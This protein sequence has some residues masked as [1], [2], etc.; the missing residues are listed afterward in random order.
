MSSAPAVLLGSQEPTLKVLPPMDLGVG[1]RGDDAV[2]LAA[3]AGLHLDPW[4]QE[5]LRASLAEGTDGRWASMI[6]GVIVARQNGKGSIL[7]A[8]ELA[9]LALIEESLILHSA[10]EFKTAI[11]AFNRILYLIENTP[12]LDKEC[13]RVIR[14]HGDEGVEFRNGSRLKFVARGSG[15]GR[16][17]SAPL[18]ILDEA[19]RISPQMIAAMMPLLSA[20]DNPQVWYTTSVPLFIDEYSEQVRRLA[21]QARDGGTGRMAWFEWSN[22]ADVDAYDEDAMARVNPAWGHRVNVDWVNEVE[23]PTMGPTEFLVERLSVWPSEMQAQW[24]IPADA[25]H[26]QADPKAERVE[27]V[28]FALDVDPDR[29]RATVG[30][31]W[32]RPDGSHHVAVVDNRRGV[33]WVVDLCDRWGAGLHV[34]P[35]SPAGSLIPDLEAAG[36]DV[37]RVA[38]AEYAAACGMFFDGIVEGSVHHDGDEVLTEAVSGAARRNLSEAWAWD[39]RNVAVDITPLVAVTLALWGSRQAADSPKPIFVH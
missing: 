10:H 12:Y 14:S 37:F 9:G 23:R 36:V 38:A 39:R 34:D 1:G 31:A 15:S 17:F 22:P 20:Q 5:I 4:Q 32:R 3:L 33:Q 6:V 30:A 26:R 11:E 28:H 13:K 25:W 16:G 27:P 19:Y 8:R 24:I 29:T 21:A 7:E 18:V 35:R 2:E